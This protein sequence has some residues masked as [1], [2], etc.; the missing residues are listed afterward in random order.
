M[1]EFMCQSEDQASI[2]EAL[3][4]IK[5]WNSGWRPAYFMIDFSNAEIAALEEQFPDS[6][7]YICDFHRYQ[8]LQRWSK[9]KKNGLSHSEQVLFVE[10]IN[11]IAYART[12]EK[13]DEPVKAMKDS[14][15]YKDHP[16]VQNY[17]EST[18][19]SC[20][21]RWAQAF[22][23][24][25]ATNIVTTNNGTEAQ[26]KL[27]KYLY[28]PQSVDKSVCGIATTIVESFIPDSNRSYLEKNL[29][30]SGA[31]GRFDTRIP[32]YLHNRPPQFI[33]HCLNSRFVAGEFTEADVT[34]VNFRKGHFN[35]KSSA[36]SNTKEFLDFS[37]P[38]CTCV[39][40]QKSHFPWQAFLCSFARYSEWGFDFLP[41]QY[42]SS[43]FIT[44]D[45]D[46]LV[47]NR[48]ETSTKNAQVPQVATDAASSDDSHLWPGTTSGIEARVEADSEEKSE[49][50]FPSN[51]SKIIRQVSSAEKLRKRFLDN[52]DTIRN[53]VY[54]VDD[55]TTMA[56]A[57][58]HL[59]NIHLLLQE[60]CSS[61]YGISFRTSP[62][63]KRL[64]ITSTKYHQIFHKKLLTR[65]RW[66]KVVVIEDNSN[67]VPDE[68]L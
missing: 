4:I 35:V 16:N 27:I 17:V 25:Q 52:M 55:E 21:V 29:N 65:R 38:S 62:V 31:Y 58:K 46:S 36:N 33:K 41:L 54:M 63:K 3:D 64:K 14:R 39:K 51:R 19:L 28:L 59:E 34:S 50:K 44:L 42:R 67:D 68:A 43:V 53:T 12:E 7:V 57:M 10:H 20:K 49:S 47:I 13:F 40:W 37:W 30:F 22:Q 6:L 60:S 15:L 8:A 66:K 56:E 26:N 9:A 18:W 61:R 45:I 1:A 24:Q 23:K 2:S 32:P 5:G 11:R 48:Q